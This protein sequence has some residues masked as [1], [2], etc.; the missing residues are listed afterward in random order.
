MYLTTIETNNLDE[1]KYYI[2][3]KNDNIISLFDKELDEIT[4]LFYDDKPN[5][6][7]LELLYEAF[8]NLI[9]E[10]YFNYCNNY[11]KTKGFVEDEKIS[12]LNADYWNEFYENVDVNFIYN[13]FFKK[14]LT[15]QKTETY[16]DF[17]K[18]KESEK[19]RG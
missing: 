5:I 13:V 15:K 2:L 3:E 11:I 4:I 16:S 9:K 7:N 8:C 6:I 17:N 18:C 19:N 1:N 12:D 14:I 10:L